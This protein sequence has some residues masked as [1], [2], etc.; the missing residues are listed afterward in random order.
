MN[1]LSIRWLMALILWSVFSS[2]AVSNSSIVINP[3][4]IP[5]PAIPTIVGPVEFS[6]TLVD[7]STVELSWNPTLLDGS[8]ASY[9]NLWDK[10]TLIGT[11]TDSKWLFTGIDRNYHHDFAVSAVTTNGVETRRSSRIYYDLPQLDIDVPDGWNQYLP[12]LEN[13][14]AE[15]ISE[16]SVKL[17][18]DLPQTYWSWANPADYS[19]A[20]IVDNTYVDVVDDLEYTYNGLQGRGDVWIGVSALLTNLIVCLSIAV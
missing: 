15:V 18:W 17:S 9:F 20:I 4:N 14:V 5:D 8:Q 6:A 3:E 1:I 12:P 13:L 16:D 10:H 7:E 2:N 11:T 19:Y